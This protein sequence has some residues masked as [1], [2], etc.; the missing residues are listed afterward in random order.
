MGLDMYLKKN[1]YVNTPWDGRT[2]SAKVIYT[3][4]LDEEIQSFDVET[5]SSF[6][7]GEHYWRKAN[8]IHGWLVDNIQQGNDDCGSYYV[9]EED[10]DILKDLCLNILQLK[11]EGKESEAVVLAQETLPPEQGF[12]FGN[13]EIDE[14]YYRSL[15]DTVEGI[16]KL[17]AIPLP[18]ND[19]SGLLTFYS[20]YEY[21]SSW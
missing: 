6:T 20:G 1:V 19:P 21:H 10:L 8:A 12:F 7:L 14:W 4:A 18:E 17:K 9:A 13:Q 5:D 2:V 16:D 3:D 15:E 11:Y